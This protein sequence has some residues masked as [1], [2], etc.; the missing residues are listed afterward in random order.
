MTTQTVIFRIIMIIFLVEGAIMFAFF[1]M[2][3][4]LLMLEKRS[5]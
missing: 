5:L 1:A 4:S 3:D 2:Q